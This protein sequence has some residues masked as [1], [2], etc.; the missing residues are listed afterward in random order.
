MPC[1]VAGGNVS[2]G[3]YGGVEIGGMGSYVAIVDVWWR[4]EVGWN[5]S[6]SSNVELFFCKECCQFQRKDVKLR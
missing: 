4:G 3:S 1:D 6:K 5:R 2:L